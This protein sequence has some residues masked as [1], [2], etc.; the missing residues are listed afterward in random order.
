[1]CEKLVIS[2]RLLKIKNESSFWALIDKFIFQ[3]RE[4]MYAKLG[5]ARELISSGQVKIQ[6]LSLFKM[7]V[8]ILKRKNKV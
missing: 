6:M 3:S 2:I 7:K 8:F 5:N 4:P 1:M